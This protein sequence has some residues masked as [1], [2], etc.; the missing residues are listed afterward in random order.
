MGY[1]ISLVSTFAIREIGLGISPPRSIPSASQRAPPDPEKVSVV[2]PITSWPRWLR[3]NRWMHKWLPCQTAVASPAYFGLA[4]S[5]FERQVSDALFT[6]WMA[7]TV[8]M[9]TGVG[10]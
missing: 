1:S 8:A 9:E 5:I 7:P 3:A 2:D 4:A 10:R 6:A